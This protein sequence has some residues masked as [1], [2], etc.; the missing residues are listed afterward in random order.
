MTLDPRA[1]PVYLDAAQPPTS[2]P[3]DEMADGHRGRRTT[4]PQQEILER[5]R[6]IETRVTRMMHALGVPSESQKAKF[7]ESA[8]TLL[9]TSPHASLRECLL[10]IP[11]TVEGTVDVYVGSDY[12]ATISRRD[13]R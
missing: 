4:D 13:T 6:R 7:D 11:E 1:P 9:V 12:V 10:A 3:E 5:A 2:K 8:G